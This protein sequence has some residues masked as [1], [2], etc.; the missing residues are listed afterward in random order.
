M[1]Q[2]AGGSQGLTILHAKHMLYYCGLSPGTLPLCCT[3]RFRW[4]G[5]FY[6]EVVHQI[7]QYLYQR[8]MHQQRSLSTNNNLL[9]GKCEQVSLCRETQISLAKCHP[10]SSFLL[11]EFWEP[12]FSILRAS[13]F[14]FCAPVTGR[15]C[16]ASSKHGFLAF[17]LCCCC[18]LTKTNFSHLYHLWPLNLQMIP[19]LTFAHS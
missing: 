8:Y 1:F 16:L 6:N 19:T 13:F 3:N 10:K 7:S 5:I 4:H 18:K 15:R 12:T 9:F 2:V 14:A 11:Q 17:S